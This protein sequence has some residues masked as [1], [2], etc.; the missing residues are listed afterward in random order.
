MERN[1]LFPFLLE[2]VGEAK[3]ESF[4]FPLISYALTPGRGEFTYK[5]LAHCVLSIAFLR[6][7]ALC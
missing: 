6:T 4:L 2:Q 5:C 7:K 3:E 1:P